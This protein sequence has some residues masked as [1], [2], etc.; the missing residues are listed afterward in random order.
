[1]TFRLARMRLSRSYSIGEKAMPYHHFSAKERHTLMYLLYWGLSYRDIG[2]RLNRHHS[3][4]AREVTRN[5]RLRNL[6]YCNEFA[7]RQAC[8]RKTQARH[9][10]KR[11]PSRVR[12]YISHKIET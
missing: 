2:R 5:G 10:R 3:T 9:Y 7:D 11:G 12:P 8:L 4:I 6:S 1:M